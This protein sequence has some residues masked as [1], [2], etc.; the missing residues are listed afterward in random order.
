MFITL[1]VPIF[2]IIYAVLFALNEVKIYR[3]GGD[4]YEWTIALSK[5]LSKYN[6]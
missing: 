1:M 3:K 6:L 5:W 4:V 2:V